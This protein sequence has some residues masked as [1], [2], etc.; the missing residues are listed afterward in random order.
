MLPTNALKKP[1]T[2]SW[3]ILARRYLRWYAPIHVPDHIELEAT[4]T[5][6]NSDA[7]EYIVVFMS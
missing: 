2:T 4:S 5:T 7:V 6:R 3:K 1:A